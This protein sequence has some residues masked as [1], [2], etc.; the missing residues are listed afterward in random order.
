MAEI[1][2][3]KG[4]RGG[5]HFLHQAATDRSQNLKIF[6]FLVQEN[7]PAKGFDVLSARYWRACMTY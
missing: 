4:G 2:L 5:S 7:F 6:I 1:S 3:Q